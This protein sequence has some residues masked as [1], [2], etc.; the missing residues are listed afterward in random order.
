MRSKCIGS[1]HPHCDSTIGSWKWNGHPKILGCVFQRLK[2]V[3][4]FSRCDLWLGVLGGSAADFRWRRRRR[5]CD[6]DPRRKT[7]SYDGCH[8]RSSLDSKGVNG[9]SAYKRKLTLLS[10]SVKL[11]RRVFCFRVA[12]TH[13]RLCWSWTESFLCRAATVLNYF[14]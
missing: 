4:F 2:T 14:K 5:A 10:D 13:G 9:V 7:D 1:V 11:P 6:A 8:H 12:A 3:Y